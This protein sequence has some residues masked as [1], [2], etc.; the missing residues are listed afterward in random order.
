MPINIRCQCGQALTL[1][2]ETVGKRVKCP[3]CQT[4]IKISASDAAAGSSDTDRIRV[5]CRCGKNLVVA[6]SAA[7]KRVKCPHCQSVMSIPRSQ[8]AAAGPR[9]RNANVE[10]NSITDLLDDVGLSQ[11]RTTEHCPECKKEMAADVLICV[12]CGFSRRLGRKMQTRRIDDEG[13]EI[14]DSSVP[15]AIRKAMKSV[16]EEQ[17]EK[18]GVDSTPAASWLLRLALFGGVAIFIAAGIYAANVA[19]ARAEDADG[20]QGG[21][22]SSLTMINLAFWAFFF[23]SSTWIVVI[24]F[25]DSVLKGFAALLTC[26]YFYVFMNW[27]KCKTPFL[28]NLAG[29]IG[30]A[31]IQVLILTGQIKT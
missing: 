10:S 16:L 4:P 3:K 21:G 29:V 8:S 23:A 13:N 5:A 25:Q 14:I 6:S 15:P 28:L 20:A 31:L 1:K 7:G 24:A 30:L 2:D 26:G 27:E 9:T 11:D 18:L 12:N 22:L 17:K 19:G